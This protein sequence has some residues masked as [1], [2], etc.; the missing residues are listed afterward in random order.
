[1]FRGT[2]KFRR[3][4]FII[5]TLRVVVMPPREAIMSLRE[6]IVPWKEGIIPLREAK[7]S[8]SGKYAS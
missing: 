5:K 2:T 1:M 8:E 4:I 6:A 3:H 7:A